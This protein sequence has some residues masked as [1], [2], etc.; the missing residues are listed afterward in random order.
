MLGVL[1]VSLA[2]LVPK[3]EAEH[4]MDPVVR[5]SILKIKTAMR[6]LVPFGIRGQIGALALQLVGE[7]KRIEVEHAQLIVEVF[8]VRKRNKMFATLIHV[9][10]RLLLSSTM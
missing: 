9:S 4:A 6:A 7:D 1:A 8:Q 5:E 10:V 2:T 3:Q